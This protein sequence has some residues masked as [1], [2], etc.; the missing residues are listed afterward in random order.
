MNHALSLSSSSRRISSA[1]MNTLEEELCEIN[2]D[3]SVSMRSGKGEGI[4]NV[5]NTRM[6][7]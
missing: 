5:S 3:S 1:L 7:S 2:K 4:L 6:I